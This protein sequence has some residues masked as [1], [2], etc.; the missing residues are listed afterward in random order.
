MSAIV[1]YEFY[2]TVYKGG[3][4]DEDTFPA[5]GAHAERMISLLTHWRVTEDSFDSLA[6]VIQKMVKLAICAQV[7]FL[8]LNG[9]ESI[10]GEAGGGFTVGKVTVHAAAGSS[11]AGSLRAAISPAALSYLEQTGLMNPQVGTAFDLG[12]VRG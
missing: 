12:S 7:D 9:L 8:A 10:Q 4:A 2:S 1:D 3:E 6:T 11:G 5:L